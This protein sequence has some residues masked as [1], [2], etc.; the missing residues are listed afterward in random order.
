VCSPSSFDWLDART[1]W[2]RLRTIPTVERERLIARVAIHE[3]C[4]F[5]S[6][7]AIGTSTI[8]PMNRG[9]WAIENGLTGG[10]TSPSTKMHRASEPRNGAA[11]SV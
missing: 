1:A 3:K 7:H 2:D 11:N 5:P 6:S 4:C 9:Q 10:W 8:E